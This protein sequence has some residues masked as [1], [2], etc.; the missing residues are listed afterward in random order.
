MEKEKLQK[1]ERNLNRR[2]N[3]KGVRRLDKKNSE[4]KTKEDNRKSVEEDVADDLRAHESVAKDRAATCERGKSQRQRVDQETSVKEGAG[5]DS[6]LGSDRYAGKRQLEVVSRI[7]QESGFVATGKPLKRY[8]EDYFL[9]SGLLADFDK[10]L[11]DRLDKGCNLTKSETETVLKHLRQKRRPQSFLA[12]SVTGVPGSGK[13]TLLRKIQTEAGLNSVVILANERHKIRFTQLP[14]CYTAKEILL[15]RT[16]IKYDVLLIDEY[17]L[18]QNGEI[19]LLQRILE[20]K[21]VVL[22][23]D[24]AQGNSRT[25]DSPEWLQIPVI[26]SSVKSRRFGKAT[27]DFCGKQGFD[28][29]GCDQEDEVQKLDFEGSSP[30]TDINLAL[31]EATIE[32]LKEVGIECSLVKDVQ[33]NEYDS[34][35]LFIREEDRAALSDPELRSVAFTRHRKL[36]IVRIPVCLMLSLFNGELNSDYR[37]QTNH[38]GKN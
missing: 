16:A 18:L 20:A 12:G 19:L 11:S 30:E 8:P 34:V 36:L 32:D 35:S 25:A 10:Y 24:R 37:P 38:Y 31:T 6:K 9:K 15:L 26:Y 13:T 4:G 1:K 17:T 28:F 23:G 3:K 29:E 5:V 27:A 2:T 7:C 33:G 14:A 22:F 21:V